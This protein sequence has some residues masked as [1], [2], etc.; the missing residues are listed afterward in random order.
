MLYVVEIEIERIL[1]TAA[2]GD[3]E[4]YISQNRLHR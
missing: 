2:L 3:I 1:R 4:R